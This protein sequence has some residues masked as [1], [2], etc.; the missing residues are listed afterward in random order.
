MEWKRQLHAHYGTVMVETFSREKAEGRLTLNLEAK[1]AKHGVKAA[2]LSPEEIARTLKSQ[3][4]IGPFVRLLATF[5]QHFKGAQM[6]LVA[7]GA[8]ASKIPDGGR[9]N[10]F[11]EVFSPVYDRYQAYLA[12]LEPPASCRGFFCLFFKALS[13]TLYISNLSQNVNDKCERSM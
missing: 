2:P 9:A 13:H 1:L 4:Q 6:G 10:A 3:K 12:K 7:L 11:V 5:L 8:R